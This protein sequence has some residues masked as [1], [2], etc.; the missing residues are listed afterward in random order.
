MVQLTVNPRQFDP[1]KN[2]KFSMKWADRYV[3]GFSKV[4]GFKRTTEVAKRLEGGEPIT[5]RKSS[6]KI[7]YEAIT[8]EGDVTHDL[9]F[10]QW[11]SKVWNYSSGLGSEVSLKD[12]SKNITIELY[13][14]SGQLAI[15]YNVF[16]T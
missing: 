14:E 2:F 11:V 10:E 7:A 4:T 15:A 13:N 8:L 5:N 9:E 12:I 3:A 1:Y 6:G 16:R